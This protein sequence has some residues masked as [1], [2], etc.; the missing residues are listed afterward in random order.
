MIELSRRGSLFTIAG[1]VS[2]AS[3]PQ[4]HALAMVEAAELD[5]P[6]TPMRLSR[7]LVR[8]MSGGAEI[9]I[10]RDW[11]VNFHRQRQGVTVSGRQ[12]SAQVDAPARLAAIAQ[13]EEGRSTDGMWPIILSE[14]GRIL[15]VGA[16]IETEDLA[17]AAALAEQNIAARS[18]SASVRLSLLQ[19]LAELQRA[20]TTLL[21][22]LPSDL[23]F[24][25]GTP[26]S[27][28][29][30]IEL[31]GG[32]TGEFELSY[33]ARRSAHGAWL[34]TA[35]RQVVTRLAGSERQATEEWALL[36]A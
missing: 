17:S 14:N 35:T 12:I 13:L 18:V 7:T 36:Q 9:R 11:E 5:I 25:V 31:P 16:S 6:Q 19:Y 27:S 26:R 1:F 29:R 24:P 10:A 2:L 22:R 15:T 21:E 3:A 4:S 28:R 34:D 8:T 23:L 32:L 30:E 20:G 33:T